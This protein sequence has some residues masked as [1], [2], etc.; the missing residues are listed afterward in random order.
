M[1]KRQSATM[2]AAISANTTVRNASCEAAIQSGAAYAETIAT[3]T[4]VDAS[5]TARSGPGI[6]IPS[7]F[8]G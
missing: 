3:I 2:P 4:S 1:R 6:E 5:L 7:G 8:H